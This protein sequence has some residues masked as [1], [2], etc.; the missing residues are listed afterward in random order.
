MQIFCSTFRAPLIRSTSNVK[1]GLLRWC[2]VQVSDYPVSSS[3]I[4]FILQFD[5]SLECL[6][7]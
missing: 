3:L 6:S 5:I 2:Q 7:H 4:Y 1:E